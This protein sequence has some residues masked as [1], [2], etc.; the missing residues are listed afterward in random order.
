[1][2]ATLAAF[3]ASELVKKGY[4]AAYKAMEARKAA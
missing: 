3:A 1:M 2:I 4:D